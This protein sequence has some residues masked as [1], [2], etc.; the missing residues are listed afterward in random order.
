[1]K[2]AGRKRQAKKWSKDK[3]RQKQKELDGQLNAVYAVGIRLVIY[4][5]CMVLIE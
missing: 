2:D 3:V 4:A 1:M 5:A